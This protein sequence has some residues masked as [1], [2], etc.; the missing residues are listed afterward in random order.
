MNN[1]Q[2]TSLAEFSRRYLR[3]RDVAADESATA[4]VPLVL[5]A[6]LENSL[7]VQVGLGMSKTN[8][9]AATENRFTRL[10]G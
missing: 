6:P 8:R 9:E 5:S 2:R 3:S 10:I 7:A 4:L 1:V